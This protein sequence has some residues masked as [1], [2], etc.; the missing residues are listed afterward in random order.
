M[1]GNRGATA[2]VASIGQSV[3]VEDVPLV[4]SET[5][6]VVPV[7]VQP[8]SSSCWQGALG[9]DVPLPDHARIPPRVLGNAG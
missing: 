3:L 1:E 6:F 8:A 2:G 4:V 5:S 9:A 7:L